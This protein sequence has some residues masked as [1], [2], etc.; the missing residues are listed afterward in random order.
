RSRAAA[1]AVAAAQ[2]GVHG[3]DLRGV[4][5]L[6][7][8][9]ACLPLAGDRVRAGAEL[10]APRLRGGVRRAGRQAGDHGP[11]MQALCAD[12]RAEYDEL[13][14]LVGS[15]TAA[16]WELPTG[17]FHWSPWD[18]VAHLLYFDEAALQALR[19]PDEFARNAHDLMERTTRGGEQM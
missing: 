1:A 10:A 8:H 16:Q 11:V 12:L 17:F 7:L 2:R 15:F 6:R 4:R 5:G 14:G 9:R 3:H 13:A 18:E 19:D